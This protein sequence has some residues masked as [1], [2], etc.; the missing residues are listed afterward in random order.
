MNTP[1]PPSITF[2][3]PGSIDEDKVARRLAW[4]LLPRQAVHFVADNPLY[5]PD[6]CVGSPSSPTASLPPSHPLH[7]LP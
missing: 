1:S 4:A 7:P 2:L 6:L 5:K 3:L